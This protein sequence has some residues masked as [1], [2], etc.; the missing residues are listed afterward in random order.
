MGYVPTSLAADGTP[1]QVELL[2]SFY[3]AV[4]TAKPSYDPEGTRMRA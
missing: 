4:V 2:G 1:L 3:D